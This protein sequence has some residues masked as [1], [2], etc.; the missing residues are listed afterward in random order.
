[1]S[2]K[3][4]ACNQN[5]LALLTTLKKLDIKICFLKIFNQIIVMSIQI[6][7]IYRF[8]IINVII[9]LLSFL[10]RI[11]FNHSQDLVP[12]THKKDQTWI[13]HYLRTE[14]KISFAKENV[15]LWASCAQQLMGVEFRGED[16]RLKISF[17]KKGRERIEKSL[18][19][20]H[21]IKFET[22]S[23]KGYGNQW[24]TKGPWLMASES[25]L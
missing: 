12:F 3:Y 5:S 8:E 17:C 16:V 4:L 22:D 1:M 6:L 23:E 19:M 2:C 11:Y 14:N 20:Q 13:S 9:I 18:G 10:R 25:F 21:A 7:I 24:I 15:C